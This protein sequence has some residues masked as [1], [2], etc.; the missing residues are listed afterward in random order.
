[1][2]LPLA[3]ILVA[4]TTAGAAAKPKCTVT[5]DMVAGA[6]KSVS[7]PSFFQEMEFERSDGKRPFSSWLHHR[8]ELSGEWKL[9]DCRLQIRVESPGYSFDFVS[10][11][12]RGDRLYLKE[13]GARSEAVYKR[14]KS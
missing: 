10:V 4:C 7:G 2:T 8:P 13:A 14:I 11:R 12:V 1:L 9:E 5:E 3:A 6:W